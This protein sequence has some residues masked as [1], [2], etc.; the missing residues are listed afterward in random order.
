[1]AGSVW[2]EVEAWQDRSMTEAY[3]EALVAMDAGARDMAA[4][5]GFRE[6]VELLEPGA[7]TGP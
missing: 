2:P 5:R 4:G 7:L 3:R 1:L 6:I